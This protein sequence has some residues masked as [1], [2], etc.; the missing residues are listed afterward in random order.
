METNIC[1][2]REVNLHLIFGM[3]YFLAS[4]TASIGNGFMLYIARRDPLK[5]FNKPTNVLNVSI[6][7]NHLFAGI[8]VLPLLGINSVLRSQELV[9]EVAEQFQDVLI[10]FVVTTSSLLLLVLFFERYTAFVYPLLNRR[11]ATIERVNRICSLVAATCFVFSCILFTGVS[12][13]IFYVITLSVFIL[14]PCMG[15]K[16]MLAISFCLL[17]RRTRVAQDI[18]H[19]SQIRVM[20]PNKSKRN[21][22]LRQYLKAATKGTVAAVLP[23][24]F[25]C[26]V[27]ILGYTKIEFSTT[28]CYDLLE[29]MSFAAVFLSTVMN[30]VVVFLKIPVYKRS[31]RH[32]WDRRKKGLR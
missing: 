3:L 22:Q 15:M 20:N 31:M 30:P 24:V 17:R 8:F 12:K 26:L 13:N 4:L 1:F 5:L 19:D 21:L 11:H 29:H 23:M 32:L 6:G 18:T 27:K 2:N 10:H 7:L 28:S 9:N 25:Y 16:V 14:L